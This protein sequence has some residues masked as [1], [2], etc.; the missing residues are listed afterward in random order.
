M[1]YSLFNVEECLKLDT[2]LQIL[3]KQA[4]HETTANKIKFI[5]NMTMFAIAT[6]GDNYDD[7][8]CFRTSLI[9]TIIDVD[10][11]SYYGN[12]DCKQWMKIREKTIK[13][14]EFQLVCVNEY[15]II[16]IQICLL[17]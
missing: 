5:A 7:T 17:L 1:V 10:K 14:Y 13:D 11:Y 2:V 15:C 3:P 12:K 16:Q 4:S 8:G 6:I 9:Y